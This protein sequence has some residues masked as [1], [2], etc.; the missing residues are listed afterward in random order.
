MTVLKSEYKLCPSCME[1]HNVDVVEVM[2]QEEFKGVEVE[3]AATWQY[4]VNSDEYFSNEAMIRSNS[5]A[6]KEAYQA[7]VALLSAGEIIRLREKCEVSQKN[8]SAIL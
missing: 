7:K 2:E 6:V 5:L 3:F 1:E 8:F 4:C